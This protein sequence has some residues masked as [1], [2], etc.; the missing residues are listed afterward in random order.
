MRGREM[1]AGVD[2]DLV[3]DA[4]SPSPAPCLVPIAQQIGAA[5]HQRLL[6]HPDEV[7]GELVGDFRA[8]ASGGDQ[9]VAA[10]DVD[11]VGERQ[12]DGVAGLRLREVAVV[13]DDPLTRVAAPGA[14]DDDGVARRDAAGRDGAGIAAEIE[15]RA[16]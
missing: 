16:G 4:W 9:Q 6:V 8:G 5:G 1:L 11:L 12:R 7:G 13:G 2:V 10:R 15:V 14:G 3:L